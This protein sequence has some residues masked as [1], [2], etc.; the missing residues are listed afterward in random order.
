MST[1]PPLTPR[2]RPGC[3]PT[4]DITQYYLGDDLTR[5]AGFITGA[6]PD[7]LFNIMSAAS[8]ADLRE[9]LA[10]INPSDPQTQPCV[11]MNTTCARI[12]RWLESGS[13]R[14]VVSKDVVPCAL[15]LLLKFRVLTRGV[16]CNS[17]TYEENLRLVAAIKTAYG[18]ICDSTMRP[19]T[20]EEIAARP[21][22]YVQGAE[23]AFLKDLDFRTWVRETDF[24]EFVGRFE[25]VWEVLL[26]HEDESVP[27][28]E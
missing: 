1:S 24:T 22:A 9:L 11:S 25:I 6:P 15:F 3:V 7:I 4:A 27:P 23:L 14:W 20:W 8:E 21:F 16:S 17:Q 18:N 10:G 26:D 28:P 2:S 5:L 12:S 13:K 19:K